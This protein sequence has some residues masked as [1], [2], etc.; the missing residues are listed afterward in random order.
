VVALVVIP[1]APASA[2]DFYVYS[3]RLTLEQVVPRVAEPV[4]G[5]AAELDLRFDGDSHNGGPHAFY[6]LRVYG[7]D[8]NGEQTAGAEDDVI[9]IRFRVAAA[10]EI[11]PHALNV[12]ASSGSVWRQDDAELFGNPSE[13]RVEGDWNAQDQMFTGP[14][15]TKLA[16]DSAPLSDAVADL[17]SGNLYIQVHTLNFSSGELRGQISPVPEP[18]SLMLVLLGAGLF[19]CLRQ[20]RD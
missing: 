15:G 14:G 13:G 2:H 4:P 20:S 9:A 10:G 12:F 1:L 16:P 19:C 8:L 7:L 6:S 5:A 18:G 11:G 17:M 3:P